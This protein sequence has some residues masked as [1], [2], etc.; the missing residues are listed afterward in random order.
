V[1]ARRLVIFG[2][3]E[4]VHVQRWAAGLGARGYAVRVISLGGEEAGRQLPPEVDVVAF[5]R[6]SRLSYLT[7]SSRA[8]RAAREFKPDL[9][10]VH[11]AAAFGLWA[12]RTRIHPLVVSTWGSDVVDFPSNWGRR[13]Y[14]R[15]VLRSADLLTATS[16]FL[17]SATTQLCPE[18]AG[19][20]QVVP[21]G[22]DIP[23]HVTPP[24][25][26]P[27]RLC[28]LKAHKRVYGL[29]VLLQAMKSVVAAQPDVQL[30]LAGEGPLT[31][32]LKDL[33][34]Q[35]GLGNAVSFAGY[36]DRHAV[37]RLLQESHVMVMPSLKEAFGVA[38]LEASASARPV[39]ATTVGGIPEVVRDGSTGLLV[40]PGDAG[41]LAEAIIKLG[42]DRATLYS[43]GQAGRKFVRKNFP[44]RRSLDMM[45]ALYEN[46]LS[47]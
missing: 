12:L 37:G 16:Q 2:W 34:Q 28:C 22:V 45:T 18:V 47:E 39:V 36:L 6:R 13:A 35:L 32:S 19:R 26:G 27:L 44:W 17:A 25:D 10:H 42:S 38:A 5:R 23:E 33:T 1:A 7:A 20:L 11:S 9:V 29:D 31:V 24:P 15:R 21:F 14:L 41:A 46:L 3:A 4:S 30:T 43:L 8:V 40:P